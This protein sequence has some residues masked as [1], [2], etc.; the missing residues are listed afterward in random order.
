VSLCIV[1]LPE[2]SVFEFNARPVP[3]WRRHV[4]LPLVTCIII[5]IVLSALF[6]LFNR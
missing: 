5:S 4:Y 3:A 2:R 1:R 6:W